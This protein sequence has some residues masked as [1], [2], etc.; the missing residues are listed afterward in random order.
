MLTL[1][2]NRAMPKTLRPEPIRE[3]A[4]RDNALPKLTQSST[5]S[6]EPSLV[7]PYTDNALPKRTKD[8]SLKQLP[9]VAI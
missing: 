4:R 7:T 3:K 6:A 2:V 9:K 8:R 5:A 1:D